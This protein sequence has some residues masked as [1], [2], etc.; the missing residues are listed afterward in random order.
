MND[1]K[2]FET[3]AKRLKIIRIALCI[4]Q[5]QFAKLINSSLS[6]IYRWENSTPNLNT[7]QKD[8]L[9]HIGIYPEWIDYGA[10]SP[11]SI[12]LNK[13]RN[14]AFTIINREINS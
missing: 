12:E 7:K 3:A 8:R 11:F 13:V 10:E 14:N 6:T 2:P 9:R 1:G 4:T 5:Y